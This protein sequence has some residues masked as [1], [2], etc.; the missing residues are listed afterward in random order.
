[1]RERQQSSSNGD[2]SEQ[3]FHRRVSPPI[4]SAHLSQNDR[5]NCKSEQSK[6]LQHTL[7]AE[8]IESHIATTPHPP[9]PNPGPPV[10]LL[11]SPVPSFSPF[12]FFFPWCLFFFFF[13]FF[14]RISLIWGTSRR[15][16]PEPGT[17]FPDGNHRTDDDL[18]LPVVL[19][20]LSKRVRSEHYITDVIF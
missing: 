3:R 1:M 5:C 14:F 8:K 4:S 16:G 20:H 18:D 11:F 10:L 13:V 17:E 15:G 7:K 12:A 2:E 6:Q 9:P 19:V